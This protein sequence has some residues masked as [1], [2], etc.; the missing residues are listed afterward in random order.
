VGGGGLSFLNGGVGGDTH[1]REN[2]ISYTGFG[3]GGGYQRSGGGGGGGYS[4]G[5]AGNYNTIGGH[6]G[7]GG[8]GSYSITGSF[9]ES[10]N[11]NNGDGYVT[12]T[13]I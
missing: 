4:G 6:G 13:K 5:A 11:L 2:Y 3:G 8:G 9:T 12:I 1:Y 7:G 10:G